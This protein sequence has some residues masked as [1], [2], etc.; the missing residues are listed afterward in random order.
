MAK[1]SIKKV[2][3]AAAIDRAFSELSKPDAMRKLGEQAADMIRK[4]TRLGYGVASDGAEREKL[5][6][7]A[8]ST[9]Q[10][11]A[12]R[13]AFRKTRDGKTFPIPADPNGAQLNMEP[14][15]EHTRASRS[16][17]THSGQL[18]DS[19]KVVSVAEGSVKVGPSGDRRPAPGLRNNNLPSN[20]ELGKWVTQAGR[21]FNHLSKVEQKRLNDEI[22]RQLRAIVKRL[23]G[24]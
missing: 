1:V 2:T 11:R 23:L 17:L 16:N 22:K 5:K 10:A 3:L 12:G 24:R 15:H 6:P 20:E 14:L 4:R 9:I 8:E 13:I 7:L 18:L 19:I 21:P